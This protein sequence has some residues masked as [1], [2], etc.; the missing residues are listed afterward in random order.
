MNCMP[1]HNHPTLPRQA[2]QRVNVSKLVPANLSGGYLLSYENDNIEAGA[3][4][5]CQGGGVAS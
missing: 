4:F 1:L 5:A 3:A 2:K